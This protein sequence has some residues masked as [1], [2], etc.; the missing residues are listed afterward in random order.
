MTNAQ[1]NTEIDNKITTNGVKAITGAILNALLK[2]FVER[3]P[4]SIDMD[5]VQG[6]NEITH[7]LGARPSHITI[8]QA[9]AGNKTVLVSYLE[10]Y[11]ND[12]TATTKFYI[13]CPD[14]MPG[15]K[16]KISL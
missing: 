5:L 14:D 10:T 12:A 2:L 3:L 4:V 13:V 1:L 8:W 9:V 15:M 7:T 16:I 11:I 6:A